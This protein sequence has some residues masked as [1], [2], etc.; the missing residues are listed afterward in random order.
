MFF[1]LLSVSEATGELANLYIYIYSLKSKKKRDRK[2]ENEFL[3]PDNG[4][5]KCASVKLMHNFC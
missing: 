1:P 2:A 5:A 3:H 4:K